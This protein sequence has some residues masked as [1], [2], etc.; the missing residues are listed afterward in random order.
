MSDEIR[1]I[2]SPIVKINVTNSNNNSVAFEQKF[3]KDLTILQLK[4]T[5]GVLIIN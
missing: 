5:N 4:V 3:S 1:I 2:T